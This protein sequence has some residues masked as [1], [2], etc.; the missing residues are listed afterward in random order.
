MGEVRKNQ[1][2]VIRL[3]DSKL[4]RTILVKCGAHLMELAPCGL[5]GKGDGACICKSMFIGNF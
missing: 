3:D 5:G 1:A 2:V 4:E